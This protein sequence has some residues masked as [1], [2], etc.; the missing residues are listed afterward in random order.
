MPPAACAQVALPIDAA[1]TNAAPASNVDFFIGI[2]RMKAK[3]E[4]RSIG[5]IGDDPMSGTQWF[6]EPAHGN[7]AGN[8]SFLR[9]HHRKRCGW[10]IWG[11][12]GRPSTKIR[13]GRPPCR[14]PMHT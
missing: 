4:G 14:P 1:V 5:A 3:K 8:A 7:D 13:H 6:H 11:A 12:A 2:P 10:S 9:E